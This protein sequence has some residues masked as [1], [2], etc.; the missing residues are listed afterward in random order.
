MDRSYSLRSSSSQSEQ[1]L[2]LL[3]KTTHV[4][5]TWLSELDATYGKMR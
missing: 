3:A 2:G 5:V 1:G 4:V